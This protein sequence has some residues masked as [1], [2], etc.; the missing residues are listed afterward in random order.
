MLKF[1]PV[2]GQ[3]PRATG[4][5]ANAARLKATYGSE[6]LLIFAYSFGEDMWLGCDVKCP[7]QQGGDFWI[8]QVAMFDQGARNSNP[9]MIFF[10]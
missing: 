3:A 8:P 10:I 4:T 1:F 9:V 2:S 5:A 6:H 7:K